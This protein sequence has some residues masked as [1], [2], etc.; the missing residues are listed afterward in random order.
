[1]WRGT[2]KD[3]LD[4]KEQLERERWNSLSKASK[5]EEWAL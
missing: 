1:M 3:Q 4:L 5:I 2:G